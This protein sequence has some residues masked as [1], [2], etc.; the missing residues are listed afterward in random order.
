MTGS[1]IRR[2]FENHREDKGT[3]RS[4]RRWKGRD[5]PR[6]PCSDLCDLWVIA[7]LGGER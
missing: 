4:L 1:D 5:F 2:T 3:Q 6:F 7:G